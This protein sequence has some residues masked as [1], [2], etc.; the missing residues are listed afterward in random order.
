MCLILLSRCNFSSKD[1]AQTLRMIQYNV[2]SG[3]DVWANPTY[4]ALQ[5]EMIANQIKKENVD[6]VALEEANKASYE[7][8]LPVEKGAGPLLGEQLRDKYE[9]NNWTTIASSCDKFDALQLSFDHNKW[10]VLSKLNDDPTG[11]NEIC[12][13]VMPKCKEGDSTQKTGSH[14]NT[15]GRPYNVVVFKHQVSKEI[16][17]VIISHN[18]HYYRGTHSQNNNLYEG[19]DNWDVVRFNDRVRRVWQE[20]QTNI[21]LNQA[22]IIMI[23]DLNELVMTKNPYTQVD[24]S[25]DAVKWLQELF[26][27]RDFFLSP[28][29]VSCC[30]DTEWG[31]PAGPFDRVI[32]NISSQVSSQIITPRNGYPVNKVRTGTNIK[33]RKT[34]N[35]E[36]K[37]VYIEIKY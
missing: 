24:T 20:A 3:G 18:P 2:K 4:R 12:W 35:Q 9:L 28:P 6:F 16:V 10:T 8:A 13:E 32:T 11:E 29:Q 36:H 31:L 14:D 23:G 7:G 34:V 33:D 17:L 30:F 5:I 21:P 25:R 26:G 15:C 22:K 1:E 37:A 19:F 27:G